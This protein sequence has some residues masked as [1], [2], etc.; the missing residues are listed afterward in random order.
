MNNDWV[1]SY[2][3]NNKG[4]M[5]HVDSVPRGLQCNCI[6]PHCHERLLARHGE[7]NEHGFAHHSDNRGANLEICYM[8]TL[9]KLA[10]QI[11]QSKKRIHA[12]SYYEIFPERDIE[13][14]DVKIDS[15]YERE[16]RQPDIIATSSDGKQYL[17]EFTIDKVL[18][19]QAI[20]YKK[21]N[22]LE[23]NLSEQT[24]ESV[25]KF[26]LGSKDKR[27]WLNNQYF[28]DHIQARYQQANKDVEIKD[29]KECESC[30]IK[31]LCAGVKLSEHLPPLIIENSG[32]QYRICKK[33]QYNKN[34]EIHRRRREEEE[35]K[36]LEE[37]KRLE[38]RQRSF[39]QR[40]EERKQ[41]ELNI[42]TLAPNELT[43][44]LC[45]RNLA[46]AN[47]NGYANCGW[48]QRLHIPQN[49]PPELAVTCK[50]FIPK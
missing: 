7:K 22:C 31:Y 40:Q 3:E 50:S 13:F 33:E 8:V 49:T 27:R 21:L 35:R 32:H 16:D 39:S 46:W 44:F 12:P 5:V 48:Y 2:A 38:E 9:Y 1:F 18:H 37:A 26:L 23:V 20:D 6:C 47:H 17:I 30:I 41:D 43:C 45:Q 36:L 11:I 25:E 4:I 14:T 10:E 19:K 28:F 34:L 15:R 29:I 24:L 42:T